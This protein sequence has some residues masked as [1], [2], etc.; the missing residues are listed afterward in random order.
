MTATSLDIDFHGEALQL[1]PQGAIWWPSEHT[2]I[3]SDVHLGKSATFRAHGLPVPEGESEDDLVRITKLVT[4]FHTQ[5]L[6]IVGDFFHS[7]SILTAPFKANL[8]KWLSDLPCKVILI[9]GNHDPL[10][11][12]LADIPR[13][14]TCSTH[15]IK[16]LHFVHDPA[17]VVEG[18]PTISGHLHPLCRIGTKKGPS[19]RVPCFLQQSSHLILPAFGTFTSGKLVEPGDDRKILYPIT[20]DQVSHKLMFL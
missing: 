1:H 13:L 7:R 2:L 3:L 10:P 18:T 6:L 16:Q 5:R 12:K 20:G 4:H 15:H 19:M 9:L 17:E 14:Q 11:H 8:N